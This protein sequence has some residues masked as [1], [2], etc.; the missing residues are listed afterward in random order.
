MPPDFG[1]LHRQMTEIMGDAQ[2]QSGA[3][4]AGFSVGGVAPRLVVHP[5]SQKEVEAVVAACSRAGAAL[6]SRGGGAAMEL[7]NPPGRLEVVVCLDRLAQIVELDAANLNVTAE[8]GVRLTDLQAA[9]AEKHLFLPLDPP[10]PDRIT[11]GGL[12]AANS[13]GP[14]RMLYG[15]VRDWV[16]GLRVVLAS[17]E[18]IRCGGK[19]VKNVSG[20]DMNKLFIGSLGTLGVVTEVTFKLLPIPVK[21]VTIVGYFRKLAQA[22][23][24]VT[25]TLESQLLPEALDLLDSQ[26]Q[27]IVAPELGLANQSGYCMMVAVAGSRETVERQV[28]DFTRLFF[29]NRAAA[30]SVLEGA[31]CAAAWRMIGEVQA[32]LGGTPDQTVIVKVAVP[33]GKTLEFFAS[34]E[35]LARRTARKGA[36]VAHAGSGIFRAGFLID[37]RSTEP[38][39]GELEALRGRAEAA[40]GSLVVEMIPPALRRSFDAWGKPRETLAVMRRLKTELDPQ[41]LLSPGRFVGGL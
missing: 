23:A 22:A 36:I 28:R 5:R 40:E 27:G 3:E 4:A 34:G 11:V 13:N 14:S 1:D 6:V 10:H 33:L 24:A 35:R 19:V 30:T 8:A 16:L 25:R 17:G 39:R 12:V 41:G 26:A 7:G 38:L 18:R 9:L 15:T 21:R 20:Y 37:G 29:E 32:R 2:V 31:R